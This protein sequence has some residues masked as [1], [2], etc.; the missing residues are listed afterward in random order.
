MTEVSF[1]Q[2]KSVCVLFYCY[3]VK[4]ANNCDPYGIRKINDLIK[5]IET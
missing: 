4:G 5:N 1:D 2:V 3:Y